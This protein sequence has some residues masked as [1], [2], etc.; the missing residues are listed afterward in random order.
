M[1]MIFGYMYGVYCTENVA[2]DN[3]SSSE[4]EVEMAGHCWIL[5]R[6]AVVSSMK[7]VVLTRG[8]E[9]PRVDEG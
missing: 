5:H 3:T 9:E 4:E 1:V 2:D 8:T 6:Q 7:L